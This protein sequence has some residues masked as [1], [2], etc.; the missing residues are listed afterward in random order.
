MET[1]YVTGVEQ[2]IIGTTFRGSLRANA[3]VVVERVL[4]RAAQ[5]P[6]LEDVQFLLLYDINERAM[7]DSERT[8]VFLATSTKGTLAKRLP[9]E[10]LF[11]LILLLTSGGLIGLSS[12]SN[13]IKGT[14]GVELLNSLAN[15]PFLFLTAGMPVAAGLVGLQIL[16][17][18][19][20]VLVAKRYGLDIGFPFWVPSTATGLFGS[21]TK[22]LSYPSNRTALFDFAISG[23]AV[24]GLL[25][26]ALYLVGLALSVDLPP[27]TSSTNEILSAVDTAQAMSAQGANAASTAAAS[28]SPVIPPNLVP[29]LSIYDV[30]SSLLLGFVAQLML[31]TLGDYASV[32]LHPLAVIGF[33]GVFINALQLLPIGQLDGGRIA[34]ATLGPNKAGLLQGIATFALLLSTFL[35]PGR[36]DALFY[37]A[38]VAITFQRNP[39]VP[40][41]DDITQLDDTRKKLFIFTVSLVFLTLLPIPI[42]NPV[43]DTTFNFPM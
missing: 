35:F 19:S 16:H 22:L 30:K 5:E 39:E 13:Y 26:F 41:A 8:P 4:S 36:G 15:D 12:T 10:P 38:L 32:S 11:A 14:G 31:P 1:F 29:G 25:S 43:V 18:L 7:P 37:F 28:A 34:S 6:E 40:C 9:V 33:A 23:P 21:V 17:D 42:S 20:H 3:S 24:A 2:S 27:P